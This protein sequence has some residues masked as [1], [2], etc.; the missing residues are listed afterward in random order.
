[1]TIV[2][3]KGEGVRLV[4]IDR[5]LHLENA[6]RWMNDPEVTASLEFNLGISRRQEEAFFDRAEAPSDTDFHWAILDERE[7]H[8]GFIGLHA[9]HWRHRSAK[10]GIVLGERS[11][12]GRGVATRAIG[13]RSR[14]A[15]ETL[16]LHRVEGHTVNPAMCRVYEKA[17][18]T[19]EGTLRE[20]LWRDGRWLDA[21]MYAILDRDYFAS[22]PQ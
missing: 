17:G 12:W 22:R 21:E 9:V 3:L 6:L 20:A 19:R 8:V 2:G 15:F 13:V 18:Y 4:P 5:T 14:F 11:A 10:G 7:A 1:M 16:G